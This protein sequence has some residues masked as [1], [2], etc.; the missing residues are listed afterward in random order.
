MQKNFQ[1]LTCCFT[2]HRPEKLQ[3]SVHSI[4]AALQNEIEFA[5]SDGYTIFLTGMS[6][7]VDLWAAELVLKYRCIHPPIKLFCA[8][9]FCGFEKNWSK[10]WQSQYCR[11]LSQADR[12]RFF[13]PSFCYA[14]YHERNR[15][16]VDHSSRVIGVYR[17]GT[18]GTFQTLAYAKEQNRTLRILQG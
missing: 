16:M 2:G 11:V 14:S 4:R 8:I 3:K 15:W 6:R 10:E 9:P 13:S 17:S 7:G 1:A 18:G 5:L 12:H